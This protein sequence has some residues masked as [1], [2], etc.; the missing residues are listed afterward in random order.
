MYR[1]IKEQCDLQ[2]L[3]ESIKEAG[4]KQAIC[5]LDPI[6]VFGPTDKAFKKFAPGETCG[7]L[8]E[9]LLYH[10][11]NQKLPAK[12]LEND[13]LYDT[14]RD[15]PLPGSKMKVRANVY[16]CPTFNDVITINGAVVVEA[17]I[18]AKNGVLHKI[19]KV[20]CPPAGSL[21]DLAAT[22]PSLSILAAAVQAADPSVAEALNNPDLSLTLFAPDNKAFENL[23]K[24]LGLT[25]DELLAFL[26]DPA[27]QQVLTDILVY[28]VLGLEVGTV[29]SAAI[30]KGCTPEVPTLLLDKTVNIKR[31]V[32]RRC[33]RK[34]DKIFLIDEL[35]RYSRVVS[36]DNLATNGVAHVIDQVILPF[37]PL[38]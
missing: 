28:H 17:D 25:L 9:I 4:L 16:S 19:N 13:K 2:V 29:F 6:T 33:Y 31:K 3:A 7:N 32:K 34:S 11:V 35:N 22:T 5:T 21:L 24:E 37:N 14:L 18:K 1:T 30:R 10:V 15:G 20:L 12:K 38:A 27:N 26:L 8:D 23:A 36:A